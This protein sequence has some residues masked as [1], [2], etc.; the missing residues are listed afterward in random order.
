MDYKRFITVEREDIPKNFILFTILDLTVNKQQANLERPLYLSIDD[1]RDGDV[2]LSNTCIDQEN[3]KG[4]LKHIAY[5]YN[6]YNY[7]KAL[8]LLLNNS[9]NLQLLNKRSFSLSDTKDLYSI[10]L[11]ISILFSHPCPNMISLILGYN[12]CNN[13]NASVKFL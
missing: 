7:T 5:F 11:S 8:R 6:T 9:E 4:V 13:L 2:L 10:L 3:D 12:V 1:E